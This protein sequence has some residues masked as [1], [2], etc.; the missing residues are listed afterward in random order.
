L[1][2][3]ETDEDW[4]DATVEV[5]IESPEPHGVPPQSV[6]YVFEADPI[7]AGGAYLGEFKVTEAPAEGKLIKLQPNTAFTAPQLARLRAT[8]GLW[9]IY[10]KMPPDE[11]DPFVALSEEQAATL[12]PNDLAES[13][14]KGT[15]TEQEMTDWVFLFHYYDMQRELLNDEKAKLQSNITRLEEAEARNQQKVAY[16]TQEIA[17]L[18]TDKQGFEAERVAVTGYVKELEAKAEKLSAELAEMRAEITKA[19]AELKALQLEAAD[20]INQRTET[21]QAG[22]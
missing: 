4:G 6:A 9:N 11:N 14:R 2:R 21:A 18:Q 16:R 15:R 13:F 1:V 7:T 17:N 5:T 20:R 12:L 22:Q 8:K 19:A 3:R 10:L